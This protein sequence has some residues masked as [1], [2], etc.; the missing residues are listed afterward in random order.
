LST[1]LFVRIG[2]QPYDTFCHL[3]YP[4][5]TPWHEYSDTA[6]ILFDCE[7]KELTTREIKIPCNGSFL[8]RVSEVFSKSQRTLARNGGYVLVRDATCRLFGYHGLICDDCA[9]SLD[10]LFGF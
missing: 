3:I 9:F 2:Q 7:G 5:S 8:W 6:L 1:R 10:H 4:A